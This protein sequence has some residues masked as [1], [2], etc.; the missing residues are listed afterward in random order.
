[1]TW[2]RHITGR[3]VWLALGLAIAAA[4]LLQRDDASAVEAAWQQQV[5]SFAA[6]RWTVRA[7]EGQVA[8]TRGQLRHLTG[9]TTKL[10]WDLKVAR[11]HQ[12]AL[13]RFADS[14][15]GGPPSPVVQKI[16]EACTAILQNCEQRVL[17]WRQQDSLHLA[18]YQLAASRSAKADSIIAAGL[19]SVQCKFLLVLP[20]LSRAHALELGL[21]AGVISTLVLKR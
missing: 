19:K 17:A 7:L 18:L 10:L 4:L 11:A 9:D 2:L 20:C 21:V 5:K 1:M 15:R 3:A 13:E 14:V 16:G 6:Y 12:E 8:G